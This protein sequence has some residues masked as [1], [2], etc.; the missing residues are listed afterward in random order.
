M[1]AMLPTIGGWF[2]IQTKILTLQE[3]S[4]MIGN[5]FVEFWTQKAVVPVEVKEHSR[6]AEKAGH[7]ERP[8]GG[9]QEGGS[10][11]P[12]QMPG[13]IFPGVQLAMPQT[14]PIPSLQNVSDSL[15]QNEWRGA[16]VQNATDSAPTI[17]ADIK[18]PEAPIAPQIEVNVPRAPYAWYPGVLGKE[19]K[20]QYNPGSTRWLDA[21]WGGVQYVRVHVCL[22]AC[23]SMYTCVFVLVH[24]RVCISNVKHSHANT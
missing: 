22:C 14:P 23:G 2:S 19:K 16:F 3:A 18:E 9:R 13:G 4:E 7:S 5:Q 24:V 17:A 6:D 12:S 21:S 15:T 10:E 1:N 20:R 8:V 11:G